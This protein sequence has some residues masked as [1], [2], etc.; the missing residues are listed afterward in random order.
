MQVKAT[1]RCVPF[2]VTADG[3][4]M[5]A[6]AGTALLAHTADWIG[7]TDGLSAAVGACRGW[8]EHDPGKVTRDIVLMLAD[9]GDALRH[10]RVLDGQDELFG[11]IASASTANRTIV[12]L[13]DDELVVERLADAR[14]AAREQ[15]WAAGGAP[16]VV[17]AA[18]AAQS[19]RDGGDGDD[20]PD[21]RLYVDVDATLIGCWCDD[22]DG[23]RRAA[24]TFKKGFGTH[25]LMVYL[26]RGD[27]LG[28][29][30]AGLLRPGSAGSNTAADHIDAFEM[31][32]AALPVLPE[33]VELVVRTDCAGCSQ[34]FL[35]Y[36]RQAGVGFSV[37]FE[38]DE[39]VRT[40]I[41]ALPDDA[42]TQAVTQDGS[43]RRGAAVAEITDRIDLSGYPP[44]SRLLVRREPLHPGA[45][46]TLWDIDGRRFTAF[47]TD[48]PDT[49]LADRDRCHRGHAHVEDRIRGA[50]DS[51]ARNLPCETFERNRVWLQFVMMAQDVMVFAQVL[52]LDGELRVAE[53]ATLRHQLLH[54]PARITRSG[55]RVRLRIQHNWPTAGALV[56][57]FNRLWAL[58]RRRWP[59][60][61][62]AG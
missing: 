32:L 26:D 45:Q 59:L 15:A 52:T 48:Q 47:L 28:E 60:P 42:W 55:R 1:R 16:P 30:L 36:L 31:A 17:A 6:R 23:R 11:D 4:G 34:E 53:P 50:K 20:Q 27:G 38:V 46:Q 37:G 40:A 29:S 7:L 3:T 8:E 9:G 35:G 24:A 22:R 25:P 10:L 19:E 12:A 13:A 43:T 33:Q 2:E 51:G 58:P 39:R 54:A 5:T 41:R 49:D 14:R 44:G 57:A 62:P 18:L 21:W 56:A 61:L